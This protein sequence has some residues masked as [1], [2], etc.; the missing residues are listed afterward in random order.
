MANQRMIRINE[1][2]RKELADL[3][4]EEIKD[5]RVNDAMVSITTVETTNDLKHAKVFISVLQDD[6][7]DDALEGLQASSKFIRKEIARRINL[8]NTPEFTFKLDTSI[9]YGMKM[10]KVIEEVM[11]EKNSHE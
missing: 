10:S 6:K 3:I 2:I 7:K 4:R 11:K 5:P 1:E 8:R 9:E